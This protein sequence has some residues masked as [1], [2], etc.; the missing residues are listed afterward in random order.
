MIRAMSDD[1]S[2]ISES[3]AAVVSA[4]AEESGAVEP[5]RA[6]TGYVSRRLGLRYAPK[7]VDRALVAAEKIKQSGL[8]VR[9]YSE[10]GDPLLCAILEGSA[11]EDDEEM[12]RVWENLLAN[13]LTDDSPAVGRGFPQILR[14][15]EPKE[16][17]FL[18]A[19]VG[20]DCDVVPGRPAAFAAIEFELSEENLDNVERL[21]LIRYQAERPSTWEDMQDIS[22][23]SRQGFRLTPLGLAFVRACRGPKHA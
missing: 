8:P 16:A 14:E 19:L 13:A 23:A 7:L 22:R 12:Q 10:V 1:A 15:L 6:T 21:N 9:A 5:F 17:R 4:L 20:T 3:V 11:L 2:I 18:D